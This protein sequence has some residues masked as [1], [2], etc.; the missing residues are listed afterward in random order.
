M[1]TTSESRIAQYRERG[2]W[3][4]KTLHDELRSAAAECGDRLAV[5][6]QPDRDSWSDSGAQRLSFAE[7]DRAADNLAW[8]LRERG[9]GHGDIVV[10]QLPNIVELVAIYFAVSRIGGIVSPIPVQ[11]GEYEIRHICDSL[12]PAAMVTLARF[13]EQSL[14]QVAAAALRGHDIELLCCGTDDGLQLQGSADAGQADALAGYSLEHASDAN[15]IVTICWTSGTTGTPKGVP[16]SHNMWTA[17][18]RCCIEAGGYQRGDRLLNPF[19]LVNMASVG[20]FLFPFVLLRSSLILHHPID[21]PLFLRQLQD[22][23]VQFTIAPPALL[24]QLAKSAEMWASF[25]FSALR[26]IG[27]GSAPL[28]PWMIE[29]FARDYGKEIINF[30]GSN[31]GI[32]L[33]CT[34]ANS[35]DPQ[36]RATMFPRLGSSDCEWQGHAANIIQTKVVAPES[37]EIIK[38]P[39]QVGELLIGGAT[40]FDGYLGIDNAGLFDDEGFFHTGDLVEICGDPPLF[41][42]IA[43]RCKDIINRGGVKLSPAE[44]DVLLEGAPGLR[45]AAVC[46]YPD[47]RLGERVCACVVVND[48]AKPPRLEELVEYLKAAGLA[49]FKLPERL[50]LFDQLPRN[51]LGKVQRF[52]L[53]EAINERGAA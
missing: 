4:D 25:D 24:N 31:E 36:V 50:E 34:P 19:P 32:A 35:G 51:P 29:T 14:L 26:A 45:E 12:Q 46:A 43:G 28:A 18:A 40:V 23:Q 8:Q 6:D 22:E 33:F 1:K 39:G 10:V 53:E 52:L 42:R 16:R 41:Y 13:R 48:P 15:A 21:P 27:S 11:Y 2:W 3:E 9:I 30:Y 7:L 20:A 44:V 38:T 37:G 49:T 5:A 17:T 47:E